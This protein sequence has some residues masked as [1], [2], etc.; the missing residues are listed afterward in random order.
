MSYYTHWEDL[1][2]LVGA[3]ELDA[4]ADELDAAADEAT[5]SAEDAAEIAREK[6]Q[7]ENAAHNARLARLYR[8]D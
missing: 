1:F 4:A 5:G 6:R 3:D 2:E 7:R 8:K